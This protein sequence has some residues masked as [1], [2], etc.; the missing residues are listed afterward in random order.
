MFSALNSSNAALGA[1]PSMFGSISQ[2]SQSQSQPQ[3]QQT[4]QQQGYNTQPSLMQAPSQN[5][6]NSSEQLQPTFLNSSTST[7]NT[8]T[9]TKTSET[10]ASSN[11]STSSLAINSN[12]K[13][14]VIPNRLIKRVTKVD[15]ST[16][17][18]EKVSAPIL[19]FRPSTQVQADTFE[20]DFAHLYKHD[21]PPSKSLFDPTAF[22]DDSIGGETLTRDATFTR[23]TE[24]PIKF[25]NVFRRY[26]RK[27]T[28][29]NNEKIDSPSKDLPWSQGHE[30]SG[31]TTESEIHYNTT[32]P[33]Y[34]RISLNTTSNQK[35]ESETIITKLYCSVIVYGFDDA[36]FPLLVDH[37]SKYGR[38]MEDLTS[39]DLNSQ[40]GALGNM[41]AG[42]NKL[43]DITDSENN[44]NMSTITST[45]MNRI[46]S[47]SKHVARDSIVANSHISSSSNGTLGQSSRISFPIFIGQGWVKI[48]YD[49]PN[50]AIRA[51]AENLTDDGNGHILG[52]IPYRREDLEILLGVGISDYLNVGDGL[53]GLSH[54]LELDLQLADNEIGRYLNAQRERRRDLQVSQNGDVKV[55]KSGVGLK[56]GSNLFLIK[57]H[58]AEKKTLWNK[59]MGFLFGT[60]EI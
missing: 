43:A 52:V 60:G 40:Y 10:P 53:K 25:Q 13:K 26:E 48:T 31:S 59:S 27:Q 39:K 15:D 33:Q 12:L 44:T 51:L 21:K 2:S 55:T 57:Q 45:N 6:Q 35:F 3:Q 9:S 17:E 56:D 58:E 19:P 11:S 50:S 23:M 54:E 32:T 41:T 34:P 47:S 22:N 29:E 46:G 37:F 42:Y 8:N 18:E 20:E 28:V 24:N 38:I 16:N 7:P 14:R 5:L 49:N 36:C 30:N 1:K 4:Q